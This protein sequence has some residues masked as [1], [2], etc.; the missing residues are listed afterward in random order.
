MQRTQGGLSIKGAPLFH[1]PVC[2]CDSQPVASIPFDVSMDGE[3]SPSRRVYPREVSYHQCGSCGHAFAPSL[4]EKSPEWFAEHV[5]N[6]DYINYDA[7]YLDVNGGRVKEQSNALVFGYSFA[8]KRIRHLDYGSGD[9]RLTKKLVAA[10]F[11]SVAYDP[12]SHDVAPAGKFNMI[13]AFEVIEHAADPDRFLSSL[14]AF[15]DDPCLIRI[16]TV[17]NDGEDINGWWYA[18]PRVGHINLF[19][20]RSMAALASRHRFNLSVVVK[21]DFFLWRNL[22]EWAKY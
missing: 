13:T 16:G 10:G 18:N 6:A 2:G 14:E 21:A 9:G 5:Y 22:P 11:D 12:F 8:R 15:M 3:N 4:I 7:D 20:K 1:C 17:P 19:S